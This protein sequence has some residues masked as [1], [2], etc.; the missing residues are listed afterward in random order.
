MKK[1]LA[2]LLAAML[3]ISAFAL[4]VSAEFDI[5]IEGSEYKVISPESIEFSYVGDTGVTLVPQGGATI[6]ALGDGE[7]IRDAANFSTKGI[8]LIKNNYISENAVTGSVAAVQDPEAVPDF[9]FALNYGEV[10]EFDTA[11]LVFYHEIASCIA[12][13][14]D[15]LVTIEISEDGD[16]WVPVGEDGQYYFNADVDEFETGVDDKEIAECAVY[17][18]ETVS[19]Q[20]VRYTFTFMAVPEGGYWEYY[21]NIYEWCGFTELGVATWTGGEEP[22]VID[23]ETAAKEPTKVEGKWVGDDGVEVKLYE[24]VNNAGVRT[25]SATVYESEAFAESGYDAEVLDTYTASYS[26]LGDILTIIYEDG[27]V[28]RMY[29][30]IDEEGDLILGSDIDSVTYTPYVAPETSVEESSEPEE[31]SEA[32][33]EES[34]EESKTE[35]KEESKPAST[36]STATSS[37]ASS[38]AP[39]DD[40]GGFPIWAI[41]L[42]AV[43]AIAVVVVIIIV[44]KKK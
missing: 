9:S 38:E 1:T 16:V 41:A 5:S 27:S 43:A 30:N 37:A 6:D 28:D 36:T 29:A 14:G 32:S 17:L 40:E 10:V 2:I 35:S 11:Y 12:I 31:S 34:K 15:K 33:E 13:P 18:G 8:V 22:V 44:A 24:F 23:S 39:A 4:A 21:C 7:I 25:L 42:I 20:Y 19:A 3:T 26:V